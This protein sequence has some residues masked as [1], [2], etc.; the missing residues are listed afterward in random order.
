VDDELHLGGIASLE[1]STPLNKANLQKE[2]SI[3]VRGIVSRIHKV[4]E[5]IASISLSMCFFASAVIDG[6]TVNGL[7]L[8]VEAFHHV[9]LTTSIYFSY[10]EKQIVN[11]ATPIIIKI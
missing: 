5:N 7:L 2:Q 4:K 10:K 11:V 9:F 3:V 6:S 1:C 8:V